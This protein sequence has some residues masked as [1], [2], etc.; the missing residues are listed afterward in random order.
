MIK[1]LSFVFLLLSACSAGV[2]QAKMGKAREQIVQTEHDFEQMAT[3]KG[4]SAAFAYYAD[5]AATLNRGGY[6]VH[7]K[8]SIR[9]IYL[10][11]KFKGVKLEWKPDFVEV[12]TS[13]DLG[14][15]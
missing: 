10:A 13:A 9:L 2:D 5:S 6:V 8:D 4:L 14:Y 7:G 1:Q 3:A 11:P 12:S 15:T